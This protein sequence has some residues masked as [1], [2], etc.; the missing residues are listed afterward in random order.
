M[1]IICTRKEYEALF[2]KCDLCPAIKA[3]H[4][5]CKDMDDCDVCIKTNIDWEITDESDN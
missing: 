2:Y 5:Y 4:G 1:K 3:T